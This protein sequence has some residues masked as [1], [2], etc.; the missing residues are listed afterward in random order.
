MSSDIEIISPSEM[1]ETTD[2]SLNK[3]L[4]APEL[5][6][7]VLSVANK[8]IECASLQDIADE[9]DVPTDVI[10]K[11]LERKEVQNYINAVFMNQGFI[12]RFR[13]MKIINDVISQKLQD[14][15]ETGV[16]SKEDLLKWMKLLD[17]METN[18]TTKEKQGP[19]V[20][21]QVNSNYDTLIEDLMKNGKKS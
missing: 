10:T 13:R 5:D 19:I 7:I 16:Y 15:L 21:I 18:A 12:N 14:A 4:E 1:V 20:A 3:S 8:Y 17:T 2:A 6:P 11:T 9:Y